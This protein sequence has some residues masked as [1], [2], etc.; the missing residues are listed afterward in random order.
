M[1]VSAE[2]DTESNVKAAIQIVI[3]ITVTAVICLVFLYTSAPI[4]WETRYPDGSY[5]ISWRSGLAFL[6]FLAV[7]QLVGGFAM[8]SVGRP[9]RRSE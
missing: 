5:P 2:P 3:G 4:F 8:R 6:L 1:M 9:G 7:G